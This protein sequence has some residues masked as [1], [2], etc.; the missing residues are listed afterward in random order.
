[1]LF[2]LVALVVPLKALGFGLPLLA[3]GEKIGELIP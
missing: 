1:M 3:V 2:G